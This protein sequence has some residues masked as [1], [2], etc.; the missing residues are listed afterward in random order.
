MSGLSHRSDVE[1]LEGCNPALVERNADEFTRIRN[2]LAEAD[3]PAERAEKKTHWH[4]EGS[5]RY[6]ARV[7]EARKLVTN[8]AEGYGKASSA[9]RSYAY[10]L[11]TAKSH[12]SNGKANE[13]A[14]A[15]LIATKGTAITREAQDAE[16]MR[17]WEDM[18]GTTGVLDFFAELTM[19]VDDIKDEANRLHDAAGGNFHLAKTT[20]KEARDI[21]VHGMK[22]AYD[23]L[24][25]FRLRNVPRVDIFSAIA[26][27]QREAHEASSN[28][29]TH[30]PGSGPKQD[31]TAQVGS[32]PVSP[33]LRDIRMQVANLPQA[34]DGYWLPPSSDQEK[35]EWIAAN[36]E[37]IQAAAK[38]SGLPPDMVAGIAWQEIAGQPG[39]ADD[40]VDTIREQADAP[41]GLSPISPENLPGRLGGSPDETSFGPIAIQVRRGA[42]VLGYDPDNLTEHQRAVVE[43]SLQDPG[44]NI[45][46]ASEYLAQLK[47][48]SEFANVPAEEMT[49]AQYQELAARY[50]GGPYW[51]GDKAQA[52]GRGFNNDL[53]NARKAL[54]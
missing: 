41:W 36:K 53:D 20:E 44:Q 26:A 51:E 16:P 45:F 39:Y 14:L 46:I 9:L 33:T 21:C 11:T 23:L 8:L 42:E 12:Y 49:S 54:R 5:Q 6:E 32:A 24:P 10:A 31:Y 47:A 22:Q 34:K 40:V 30:L 48:E 19:D 52:Y 28:P 18:R 37:I 25:E 38:N 50:N 29:L 3:E 27:M 7:A 43:E 2:M 17:Q 4:S 15:E 1:F 35:K 13:Q